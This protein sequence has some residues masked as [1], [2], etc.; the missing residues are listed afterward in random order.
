MNKYLKVTELFDYPMYIRIAQTYPSVRNAPK[1]LNSAI[2]WVKP[3]TQT[4]LKL[5]Q[6]VTGGGESESEVR[7]Q[8]ANYPN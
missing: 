7:F 2:Y 5:D 3:K 6:R 4:T 1:T 8:L